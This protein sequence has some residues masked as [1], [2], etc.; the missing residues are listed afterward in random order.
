MGLDKR[1][2][3]V[4]ERRV[5][6]ANGET[7]FY[8]PQQLKITRLQ[9]LTLNSAQMDCLIEEQLLKMRGRPSPE[10]QQE[11]ARIRRLVCN[12]ESSAQS[13]ERRNQAYRDMARRVVEL[14]EENAR[15]RDYYVMFE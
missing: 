1:K 13:R 4:L 6:R 7:Q 15:L 5:K 10:V 2:E 11:I 8:A 3:A 14:E 9:V 12:R